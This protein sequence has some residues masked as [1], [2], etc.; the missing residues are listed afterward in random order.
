MHPHHQKLDLELWYP[1]QETGLYKR[2]LRGKQWIIGNINENVDHTK[3]LARIFDVNQSY[4][5]WRL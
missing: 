1:Q 5:K 4:L 2:K 3:Q